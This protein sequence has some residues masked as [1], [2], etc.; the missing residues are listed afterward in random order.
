MSDISDAEAIITGNNNINS[1]LPR[2]T[3]AEFC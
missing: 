1:V 3:G 2:K